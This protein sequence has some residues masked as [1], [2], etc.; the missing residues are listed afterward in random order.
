M[1]TIELGRRGQSPMGYSLR[2]R[3]VSVEDST[4]IELEETAGE[5]GV[6]LNESSLPPV[7][8]GKDAWMFLAAAFVIETLVWG[9]PFAFGIFQSYYSTHAPF[10]GSSN[11][12]IIGTCA[13]GIMY[14][15][16]PL[17]F[18][19]IQRWQWTKR[20]AIA[21]GLVIMCLALGLSSLAQNTT[22][23]IV[24]QGV[25]YAIGGGLT[26][27]PVIVYVDEWFVK[28]KGLAYGIMW[29]GTGLGGVLIP[30][31]LQSL[32]DKYGFRTALRVWTIVLFLCTIPL[33]YALKPRIPLSHSSSSHAKPFNLSF[34]TNRT[35][36]LLQAGN[37]FEGVGFFIPSIYLPTIATQLGASSSISALT[38][39]MFNVASVFGCVAM[40]L[41]IDRWHVTTC[42]LVSTLGSTLSIFLLWGLSS[43]LAPLFVFCVFYGLFAGSF[44]S[45]YPGVMKAVQDSTG[46]SDGIMVFAMLAAGRGVGNVVSGPVSEAMVRMGEWDAGGV[47][48]TEWGGLVVFTGVSALLGG[49]GFVGR[50]V[51]WV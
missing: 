18:G 27:S 24:T 37:I 3:R 32:L 20:P 14:L 19:V 33:I 21:L 26:Y 5:Q 9:F 35:F 42:I 51:G 31:L 29:A 45:T 13:M 17:V 25:F 4:S 10:A 46:R 50:R 43:S 38:V 36:L 28:R 2:D 44:T 1:T 41:V 48:G 30:I 34:L 6:Q 7:D 15:S 40:G 47:Y 16:A 8:T 23:L 22:H 12:A 39:I 49:V 11:V